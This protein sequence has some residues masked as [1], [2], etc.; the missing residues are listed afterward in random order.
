MRMVLLII[1]LMALHEF[2][3]CQVNTI[4]GEVRDLQ[5]NK[6]L[7]YVN[8]GIAN[9]TVGTVSDINGQFKLELN[10]KVT[11]KDTI[12]FSFI[13]YETKKLLVSEFFNQKKTIFLDS[14]A[15]E[16]DEVI[17]SSKII[18]RK[19]REFGKSSKGMGLT[20]FNFY[21]SSEKDVDDRLSKELGM[22]FKIGRNCQIKDLN[23]N[24]TSN[25]FKHLKFRV[26]IYRIENDFPADLIVQKNIVF[27]VNNNF[28]GWF[29]LDLEPFEIYLNE[30]DK[31][32]AVTIQWL[33][34]VKSSEKSKYFSISTA[35]SPINTAYFR[36]KAMDS[37]NKSG[38]TLSFYL[39]AL[40]E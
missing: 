37:W 40:C 32:V 12:L 5:D 14:K 3:F 17:V 15:M 1:T 10:E 34:S 26:N 8:I 2:G 28:V 29:N 6:K 11:S 13:G 30:K 39:N 19:H 25:D 21:T 22:K 18:K 36:E 33:E 38:Q 24:I 9:K 27:E 20:H 23:F 31:E 4:S 7:S 35:G 16:L